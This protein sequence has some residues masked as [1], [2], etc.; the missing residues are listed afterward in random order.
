[1]DTVCCS[2]TSCKMLRVPSDILS[3]SSMQQIPRSDRTNAPDSSTR[4]PESGSLVMY[5]VRPTAEDP[6]P[7]VYIPHGATL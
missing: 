4:S 2:I 3:N 6:L 5:A 1:M 7:E